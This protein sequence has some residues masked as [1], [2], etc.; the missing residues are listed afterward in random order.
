MG[1]LLVRVGSSEETYTGLEQYTITY[2]L[3][4]LVNPGVGADGQDEIYWNVLPDTSS[5]DITN[6]SVTLDG[7]GRCPGRAVSRDRRDRPRRAPR[8]PRPPGRDLHQAD[9]PAGSF[10]TVLAEYP[11]GTFEGPTRSSSTVRRR[12]GATVRGHPG[13]R[14]TDR[15]APRG[16]VWFM[17]RRV[18][19][20]GRDE[21]FLG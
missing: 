20:R 9:V 16:G 12:R 2:T 7:P 4:G 6:A 13:V 8:T 11:A 1:N 3:R 5:V 10:F 15:A 14:R 17:A 21:Q 19:Q 18:R